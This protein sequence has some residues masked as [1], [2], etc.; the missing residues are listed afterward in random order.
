MIVPETLE[1]V[2]LLNSKPEHL[3]YRHA[4]VIANHL[5]YKV[6]EKIMLKMHR[7][8]GVSHADHEPL[9]RP[10]LIGRGVVFVIPENH[11]IVAKPFDAV[12]KKPSIVFVLLFDEDVNNI[13]VFG[14]GGCKGQLRGDRRGRSAGEPAKVPHTP[15]FAIKWRFMAW[16]RSNSFSCLPDAHA[17]AK[18][19]W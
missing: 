15:T 11:D 9:A 16:L 8:W 17:Q 4:G 12:L 7:T 5:L 10:N 3:S 19:L 13:H 6:I 14:V 18:T 2:D 1:A